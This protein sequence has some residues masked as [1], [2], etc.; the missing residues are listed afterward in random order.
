MVGVGMGMI[1]L[2]HDYLL[3]VEQHLNSLGTSQLSPVDGSNP[4]PDAGDYGGK[5]A[6]LSRKGKNRRAF[7]ERGN[8][9]GNTAAVATNLALPATLR[10][11]MRDSRL[12][13]AFVSEC[14]ATQVKGEA[15]D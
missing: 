12:Y 9:D 5:T 8:T 2:A 3:A 1:T 10:S 13:A 15:I 14:S 6:G 7:G 4:C 11:V